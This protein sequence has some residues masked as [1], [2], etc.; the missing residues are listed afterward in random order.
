MWNYANYEWEVKLGCTQQ[1]VRWCVPW[2]SASTRAKTGIRSMSQSFLT[3]NLLFT[4]GTPLPWS[5]QTH[6]VHI[7]NTDT[8]PLCDAIRVQNLTV[9]MMQG[10]SFVQKLSSSSLWN[11]ASFSTIRTNFADDTISEHSKRKHYYTNRQWQCP[12]TNSR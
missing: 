10:E 12:R 6:L 1:T 8:A 2:G 5:T 7:Q 9:I 11:V 3:I 4:S